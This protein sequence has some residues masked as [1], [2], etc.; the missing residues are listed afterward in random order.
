MR[1]ACR[2]NFFLRF[3]SIIVW[4]FLPFV[5]MVGHLRVVLGG[6]KGIVRKIQVTLLTPRA[7]AGWPLGWRR[8]ALRLHEIKDENRD[9]AHA[10]SHAGAF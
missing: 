9:R 5:T 6:I 2:F 3:E 10:V 1:T 7:P 8:T 4:S